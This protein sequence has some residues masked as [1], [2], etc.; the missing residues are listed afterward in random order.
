MI[1]KYFRNTRWYYF[2]RFIKW[3]LGDK[4]PLVAAIK[5]TQRCNIKC[6]HC[7][8]KNKILNELK[9]DEWKKIIKRL[10]EFGCTVLTFEGGEPALRKDLNEL[11]NYSHK[12]GL[13]TI[14]VTNGTQDISNISPNVFW[15]SVDGLKE[16]HDR[17]R[18]K[19]VF[20]KMFETVKN[21]QNKKIILLTTIS[22]T[23]YKDLENICKLFSPI[24]YGFLFHFLYPYKEAK[25]VALSKKEKI[26]VANKL[27]NNFNILN[28]KSYLKS[29]STGWKCYP[30]S[31]I[32]V[33]A[34]GN[35]PRGCMV[36]HLEPCNCDQCDMGCYGEITQALQLKQDAWK[37]FREVAEIPLR[38][39]W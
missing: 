24:V 26:K 18:G 14:V 17:I 36:E 28:S 3:K 8:W 15:F 34:D 10:F 20:E 16:S 31:L 38:L 12:L 5:I 7:P 27:K 37:F 39:F 29:I 4:S 22:K 6:T 32:V 23:N 33:T 30:W 11:I 9:T 1:S 35:F 21:N 13:K 25:D 19:G 2:Y